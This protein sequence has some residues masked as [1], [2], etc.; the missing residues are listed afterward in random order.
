MTL[1]LVARVILGAVF[2]WLGSNK[3]SDPIAFLKL[4]RQYEIAPEGMPAVLNTLAVTLPWVEILCGTLLLLGIGVRG[5]GASMLLMLMVFSTAIL[6][7]ALDIHALGEQAFCA[8]KF[9]CGC[10]TGEEFVCSKLP[11]NLGL[12]FLSL[13]VLRSQSTRLCL[14]ARFWK[15]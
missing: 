8:I 5:V 3:V 6:L 14:R 10:G 4:I 12:M 15:A 7:R 2:I 9:D 1:F 11:Q 13:A